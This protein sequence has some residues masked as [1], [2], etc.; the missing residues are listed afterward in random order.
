MADHLV[1]C[2]PTLV[3]LIKMREREREFM[4]VTHLC[5]VVQRLLLPQAVMAQEMKSQDFLGP[6]KELLSPTPSEFI[7]QSSNLASYIVLA[8]NAV[9]GLCLHL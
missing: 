8:G 4:F 9:A 5:L 1:K 7:L 3:G 6:G 2:Q